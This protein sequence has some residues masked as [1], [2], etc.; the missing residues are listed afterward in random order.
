MNNAAEEILN[1]LKSQL[2]SYPF[3][4]GI[5][6]IPS[7]LHD[8][9]FVAELINDFQDLDIL[10]ETKAFRWY[11]ESE[12]S[13]KLKNPRLGLRRWLAKAKVWR[14]DHRAEIHPLPPKG[15]AI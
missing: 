13:A 1:Y 4:A 11:Y 10:E 6:S 8:S 12:P 5:R 9:A 7:E 2:A 3:H 14:R 15:N